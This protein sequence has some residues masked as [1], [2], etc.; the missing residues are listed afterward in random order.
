[1]YFEDLKLCNYFSKYYNPESWNVPLLAV[2][3][4]EHPHPFTQGEA[5]GDLPERIRTLNR[6]AYLFGLSLGYH[7]CSICAANGSSSAPLLESNTNLFVPGNGVVYLAPGRADHYLDVHA[8]LPPTQ[9]IDAV[10]AC[11]AFRTPAYRQALRAS[12]GGIDPPLWN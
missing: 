2:G 8:Y 10:M 11:P 6:Q 9:F 5:P 1:M 3:W 4:L 7:A 12:N